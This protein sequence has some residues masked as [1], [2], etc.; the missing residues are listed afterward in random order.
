LLVL[1][2]EALE[3]NLTVMRR[4]CE[5]VGVLLAPHGKT[6][7]APQL[8]ARQLDAGAWGMTAATVQQLQI[9]RMFGIARVIFANQIVGPASVRFICSELNADEDFELYSFVDSAASVQV[10]SDAAK[11]HGVRRPFRVLLEVGYSGGRTGIRDGDDLKSV[12]SA[13]ERSG[14]SVRLSG[15][16]AY[17]GLLKHSA[18]GDAQIDKFLE[19]VRDF[20]DLLVSEERLPEEFI[21]TAGGSDAFDRVVD[22]F[23]DRWK[24]RAAVILRAGCYLTHDDSPTAKPLSRESLAGRGA[25][26]PALR[27]WSYVQSRPEPTLAYLAF[28]KRDAPWDAGFPVPLSVLRA[29]EVVKTDASNFAIEEMNDQH[30]RLRIPADA[31][32]KVGDVVICGIIHPCG[33]FDRWRLIFEVDDED[34]IQDAIVTFF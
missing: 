14:G 10:L 8:F 1:Q 25:L 16:A 31:S 4:Y 15:V 23:A 3:N 5:R 21:V 20:V 18:D 7:M 28:G 26:Q 33:A 12:L 13:I 22:A 2:Q 17:E 11:R 27:L 6:T 29:G 24:G 30:A 32:L 19:R 34:V 9:Y